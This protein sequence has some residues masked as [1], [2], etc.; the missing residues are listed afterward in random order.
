MN[1]LQLRTENIFSYLFGQL[2][3]SS[4]PAIFLPD[5]FGQQKK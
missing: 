3:P 4:V 2:N 5:A 1:Y